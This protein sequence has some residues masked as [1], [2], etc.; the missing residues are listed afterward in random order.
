MLVRAKENYAL[1]RTPH[2]APAAAPALAYV[3]LT[4]LYVRALERARG[5]PALLARQLTLIRTILTGGL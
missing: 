4:P 1:T 3:G 2:I 5:D